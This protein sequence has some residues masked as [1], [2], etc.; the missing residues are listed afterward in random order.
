MD[1]IFVAFSEYLN[2]KLQWGE[3]LYEGVLNKN[4]PSKIMS[5]H[6]VVP[7][8]KKKFQI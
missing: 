4:P 8:R 2:F 7:I 5:A 3:I 6:C 1:Q